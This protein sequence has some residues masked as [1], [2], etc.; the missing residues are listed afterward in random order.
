MWYIALNI[1][2]NY[3]IQLCF[4]GTLINIYI[5]M[6]AT[7]SLALINHIMSQTLTFLALTCTS[8]HGLN[9]FLACTTSLFSY[10]EN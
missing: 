5:Y 6:Y 8:L 3:N 7:H 10:S 4:N 9:Y 2:Q 1:A